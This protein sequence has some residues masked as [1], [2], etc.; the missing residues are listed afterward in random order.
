[1]EDNIKVEFKDY[2]FFML[3]NY[4]YDIIADLPLLKKILLNF[5]C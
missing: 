3:C 2:L 5:S 4:F 1:M